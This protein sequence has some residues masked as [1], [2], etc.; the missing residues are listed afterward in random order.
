LSQKTE[1]ESQ[2]ERQTDKQSNIIRERDRET[3]RE[4]KQRR[5][6]KVFDILASAKNENIRL[7]VKSNKY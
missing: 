3:G 5:E 1:L 4:L 2:T 6:K 7:S